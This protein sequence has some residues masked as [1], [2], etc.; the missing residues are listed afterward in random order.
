MSGV[1]AFTF[2]QDEAIEH[3]LNEAI[4]LFQIRNFVLWAKRNG[5]NEYEGRHWTYNSRK[6]WA[7]QF[8]F[9]TEK[10]VRDAIENLVKKG[11]LIKGDFAQNRWRRPTYLSLNDDSALALEGQSSGPGGP[12]VI[13]KK[14]Q[15][16]LALEGQSSYIN[17]KSTNNH[18]NNIA[19][20]PSGDASKFEFE[21]L[22]KKFPRKE[23]KSRGLKICHV[24]IKTLDDFELLKKAIDNYSN[25]CRAKI[26]NPRF[27][28]HFA[29]F[30]GE[31][32][33]WLEVESEN[34]HQPTP[35]EIKK[36]WGME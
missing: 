25:Y 23:G 35:E 14:G 4:I 8:G 24:Q 19:Q 27:I 17:Y 18:N 10:Q 29:T 28:K 13:V 7:E 20:S 11:I 5:A 12:D 15:C 22:Y 33:D 1:G 30:M 36:L 16:G 21:T 2:L 6:A 32:R 34:E 26:T 9:M 3:G 31:W